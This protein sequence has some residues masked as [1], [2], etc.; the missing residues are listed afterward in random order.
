[1]KELCKKYKNKQ[2]LVVILLLL[3]IV[4]V[5]YFLTS[6]FFVQRESAQD[7]IKTMSSD[8]EKIS[9]TKSV[10]CFEKK[11]FSYT[12]GHP[13]KVKEL[14]DTIWKLKREGKIQTDMRTFSPI[15]HDVGMSFVE[16]KIPLQKALDYCPRTFRGGCLHGV[17]MEYIDDV[18]ASIDGKAWKDLCSQFGA[19]D[20][21]LLQNCSHALGHEFAAKTKQSLAGVLSEC[22]VLSQE[23]MQSCYYG[24]FMEYSK[25]EAGKGSHSESPVGK[26]ELDCKSLLRDMKNLCYTSSGF[27]LVYEADIVPWEEAYLYCDNDKEEYESDCRR[28]VGA[29]LLFSYAGNRDEASKECNNLPVREKDSCL[30]SFS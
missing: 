2:S 7:F 9:S 3:F 23:L 27:Y 20:T 11:I 24:V 18:F 25:G 17:I 5:I 4:T 1:M 6:R 30:K 10:E 12:D 16:Q 26:Y 21:F 14:F 22:E 19:E 13:E 28:G 15:V 8:C 29:A